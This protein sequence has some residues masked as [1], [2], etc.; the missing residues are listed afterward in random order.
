MSADQQIKALYAEADRT[1]EQ[2]KDRLAN[3]QQVQQ[4]AMA[5]T[6]EA[7]S[8]DGSVRALVDATGVVTSLV[9]APSVFERS[10]P[11]R[12][13]QT[14][15]AT[16]QRAAAQARGR[17]SAAMT[18]AAPEE[19]MAAEAAEALAAYG[20]PKIGV[21]EVPRTAADPTMP[22]TWSDPQPVDNAAQQAWE[23][24][25]A[26]EPEPVQEAAPAPEPVRV[27]RASKP[28][29][30]PAHDDA[31]DWSSDERPW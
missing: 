26:S 13:A 17:M 28:P 11:E 9:L 30:R 19:G 12:L 7:S 25:H 8:Q 29:A 21:P 20:I 2:F 18:P 24:G 10:T 27:A 23:T 4:Q 3:I 15:V 14:V 5:A 22:E 16:I 1:M 31:D 6:G